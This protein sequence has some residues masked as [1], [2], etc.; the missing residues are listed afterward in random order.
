MSAYS[1]RKNEKKPDR[2]IKKRGLRLEYLNVRVQFDSQ[3]ETF[4]NL[5]LKGEKQ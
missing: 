4:F 1:T 3:D 2:C 5:Q